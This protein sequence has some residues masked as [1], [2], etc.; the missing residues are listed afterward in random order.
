MSATQPPPPV[1]LGEL[2]PPHVG[3][4][5]PQQ[6]S[7]ALRPAMPRPRSR[8]LRVF[9]V[10]WVCVSVLVLVGGLVLP[11]VQPPSATSRWSGG[12][13]LSQFRPHLLGDKAGPV[14][15]YVAMFLAL[16]GMSLVLLAGLA[17]L[18]G[19]VLWVLMIICSVLLAGWSGLLLI[20]LSAT[21]G[22]SAGLGAMAV[23]VGALASFL[24]CV[25]P[26]VKDAWVR[27]R[28]F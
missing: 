21:D 2:P 14:V 4:G 11:F 7:W 28:P 24:C 19:Q 8:P 1:P 15:V 22:A 20:G 12:P 27:P 9:G 23:P 16:T 5:G 18:V 3:G 25:I 13:T 10:A 17:R 26:A 6:G